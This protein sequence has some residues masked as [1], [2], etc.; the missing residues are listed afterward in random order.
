MTFK[1]FFERI[2]IQK[3]CQQ[4][5][6]SI[7]ACPEFLFLLLGIIIIGAMV[8]TTLL[9]ERYS[10]EPDIV[11]VSVSVT[12]SILLVIGNAIVGSFRR[13]ADASRMKSEFVNI[14]SHQLR[15]P[16]SAIKWQLE[17][18]L[19]TEK[20]VPPEAHQTVTGLKDQNERMINLVNDL[21]EVNRIEDDRIILRPSVIELD[22]FVEKACKEYQPIASNYEI[23][24]S[25]ECRERPLLIFVD[26]SKLRWV[27]DNL[28]DNALRYTLKKGEVRV[29]LEHNGDRARGEII[30][31]G[32]GI[33]LKDQAHIFTK[34]F[35]AENAFRFRTEGSGLGLYIVRALTLTMGGKVGFASLEG[36]GSTFW[37]EFPLYKGT[38][39]KQTTI[40]R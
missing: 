11:V 1:D 19:E 8:V 37:F 21:L 25:F 32:I 36:K 17:L 40:I 5:H 13:L 24:L 18:M 22:T 4:Y 10:D 9:A 35:R 33:P 2:N 14:V 34:F 28:I 16:L 15:S 20:N 30:D 27:V 38:S 29:S 26:E 7:F 39:Q 31:D 3:Q 6:V 12:T 23:S